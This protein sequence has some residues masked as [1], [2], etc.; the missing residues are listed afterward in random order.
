MLAASV[1]WSALGCGDS[2]ADAAS[3]GGATSGGVGGAGTGLLGDVA[4]QSGGGLASVGG[5][6]SSAGA[7]APSAG[8]GGTA[9]GGFGGEAGSGGGA[10]VNGPLQIMPIG[11]SITV[12]SSGTNAGYRGPLYRLLKESAP[13]AVYVG[14]SVGGPGTTA[15]DPL[16]VDQWHHEGHSSYTINDVNNNLDGLDSATFEQYGGLDRDP[17]GGHWLDGIPSGPDTRPALYPDIITMM[18]GTNNASNADR[19]AVRNQLNALLTKLTT[20]RPNAQVIVAQITPSN[21]PN[22]VSFNA[23]VASEA[24]AFQAAGKHVSVVDMFTDF[25]TDGLSNDGVHPNDKGYAFMSQQWFNAI[26]AVTDRVRP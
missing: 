8:S 10:A 19:T 11:D 23:A 24:E 15:T 9:S 26:A 13:L 22:N 21:R 25:P 1:A 16:P 6:V 18:I 20:L 7:A 3:H 17:N 5:G 2:S 14:S 4:G 12:G